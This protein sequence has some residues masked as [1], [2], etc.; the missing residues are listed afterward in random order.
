M[1]SIGKRLEYLIEKKGITA[2]ELSSSTGI[3]QSTLSRII[4]KGSKPNLKNS[5]I[6]A[7]YFQIKK[8]WLINGSSDNNDISES[9]QLNEPGSEYVKEGSPVVELNKLLEFEADKT[10]NPLKNTEVLK[11]KTISVLER[12]NKSLLEEVEYLKERLRRLE[13]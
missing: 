2:Y 3:S 4:H 5:D 13:K 6:L 11:D 9:E 12:W 10:E 8:E 1:N 7:K